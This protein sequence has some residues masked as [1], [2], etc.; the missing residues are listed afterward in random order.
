MRVNQFKNGT[1]K[2]LV[3]IPA[4]VAIFATFAP[5]ATVGGGAQDLTFRLMNIERRLDQLQNRVDI[6]ERTLQ[7]QMRSGAGSSNVSTEMLL[8]LQRQQ[9]QLAGQ[10]VMM[11]RQMLEMQKAIDRLSSRRTDQEKEKTKEEAKPK[12][13]P[14]KP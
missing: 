14:K 6:I 11:Q 5:T 9:T 4:M 10:Q 2:S 12:A 13:Q 3:I 7:N 8:E 1:L